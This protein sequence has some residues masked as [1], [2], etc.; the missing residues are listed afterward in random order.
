MIFENHT[1]LRVWASRGLGVMVGCWVWDHYLGWE[2]GK[3]R[4]DISLK[5]GYAVGVS[6]TT[7][8]PEN[9]VYHPV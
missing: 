1:S 3:K 5:T 6:C 4:G 8:L 7:E 9:G 2:N